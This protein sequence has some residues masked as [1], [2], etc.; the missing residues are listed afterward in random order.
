MEFGT[1]GVRGIYGKD[2]DEH[3]VFRA[4]SGLAG[5]WVVSADARESSM[6]LKSAASSA[7]MGSGSCVVDIGNAP[8]G[9][10]AFASKLLNTAAFQFTAS[11]N[12]PEYAG[13]KVFSN[14]RSRN[15]M[16]DPGGKCRPSITSF[17]PFPAYASLFR[18]F[19]RKQKQ[20]L[21]IDVGNGAAHWYASRLMRWLGWRFITVNDFPDAEKPVRPLEPREDTIKHSIKL[22]RSYEYEMGAALDGDADRVVFFD[23][24]GFIGYNEAIG[25]I[26][27]RYLEMYGANSV[28]TTV[29]TGMRFDMLLD[30]FNVIR[31][32]V[33]DVNVSAGMVESGSPIGVEQPG[34]YILSSLYHAPDVF[35]PMLAM[36]SWFEPG[37]I[38]EMLDRVPKTFFIKKSYRTDM[39]YE[40]MDRIGIDGEK[41][42]GVL[43][44]GDGWL[45]LVRPSGTENVI[46]I[47]AEAMDRKKAMELVD[48][49]LEKI[50]EAEAS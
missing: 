30:G 38:R 9:I 20:S 10:A 17:D 32:K 5:E 41:M 27:R 42:D 43:A 13:F 35:Y 15:S 34:H 19:R 28:V 14:G 16:P 25:L 22:L 37:E 18:H 6:S 23:G 33:G 31:T 26:A 7:L 39:K 44:R 12:P 8:T 50:K 2:I 36:T 4:F 3:R 24:E 21:M 47:V 11:H 45:L 46:R 29:E 48:Y 49:A 40:I 1:S